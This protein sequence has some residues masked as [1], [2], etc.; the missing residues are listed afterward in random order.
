MAKIEVKE[1]KKCR[2]AFSDSPLS[3]CPQCD[4]ALTIKPVAAQLKQ[5]AVCV[6]LGAPFGLIF[7]KGQLEVASIAVVFAVLFLSS[8]GL[9]WYSTK[10]K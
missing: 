9:F 8:A 1:C 3:S 5:N 7:F 10:Y 2:K 4:M 6:M